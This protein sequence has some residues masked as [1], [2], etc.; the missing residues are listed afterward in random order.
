[1]D[2]ILFLS[3]ARAPISF[4]VIAQH[5][6]LPTVPIAIA[7]YSRAIGLRE[8]NTLY[9][10]ILPMRLWREAISAP[11]HWKMISKIVTIMPATMLN[12][13]EN[14]LFIFTSFIC[15]VYNHIL[16]FLHF[17]PDFSGHA[18]VFMVKFVHFFTS[19]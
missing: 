4:A 9:C 5:S 19:L 16:D 1:M 10:A 18:Q 14:C 11:L 2:C 15:K 3:R 8:P 6:I 7:E 12:H 13:S 17:L